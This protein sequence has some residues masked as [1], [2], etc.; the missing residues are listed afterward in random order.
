MRRFL[1]YVILKMVFNALVLNYA[2]S[3]FIVSGLCLDTG[4]AVGT[5]GWL[6]WGRQA[7]CGTAGHLAASLC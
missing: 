3:A 7:M 4:G 1:P 2:A 5:R 6:S